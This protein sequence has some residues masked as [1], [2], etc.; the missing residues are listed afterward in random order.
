MLSESL[1]PS[2][3]PVYSFLSSRL[4]LSNK[5]NVYNLT[6]GYILYYDFM[7]AVDGP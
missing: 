4:Y 1:S 7:Q 3:R 2:K 5:D 6:C